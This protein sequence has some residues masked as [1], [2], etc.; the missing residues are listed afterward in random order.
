M[1]RRIS[2]LS[3]T[4]AISAVLFP[5]AAVQ[6]QDYWTPAYIDVRQDATYVEDTGL[7]HI[8]VVNLRAPDGKRETVYDARLRHTGDFNF[9]LEATRGLLPMQECTRAEVLAAIPQLRLDMDVDE[10]SALVGCTANMTI[11]ETSVE[12]GRLVQ[13]SWVGRDG[14]SNIN[15]GLVSSGGPLVDGIGSV[16]RPVT[17]SGRVPFFV[18]SGSA[19]SIAFYWREGEVESYT[20]QIANEF[21][22]CSAEALG[23]NYASVSVGDSPEQVVD[24]LGCGPQ[25]RR[26]T[27]DSDGSTVVGNWVATAG[28]VPGDQ[29]MIA[30][31]FEEEVLVSRHRTVNT[32]EISGSV[33]A[34]EEL[35]AGYA[36]LRE[37]QS[38]DTL[39]ANVACAPGTTTRIETD[40]NLTQVYTWQSA[41]PGSDVFRSLNR[42][43]TVHVTN[44][45]IVGI[46][47][48]RI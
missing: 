25:H 30:M 47:F 27:V 11:V 48:Q 24:K 5:S 13:T 23:A 32:R 42:T 1:K 12:T 38:R 22:P 9:K 31:G 8:P 18:T 19:P 36:R 39:L 46:V 3:F 16:W 41:V 21:T 29:I 28:T 43:L 7:L 6:A 15:P 34:V 33:C 4:L 14:E 44:G 37:G 10:V 45:V 17:P 40:D 2:A 26:V 35:T 20:Y